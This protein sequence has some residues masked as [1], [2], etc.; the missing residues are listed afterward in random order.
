MATH[1]MLAVLS[2]WEISG[3]RPVFV[4][5]RRSGVAEKRE[6]GVGGD[7]QGLPPEGLMVPPR[8]SDTNGVAT[9][10]SSRLDL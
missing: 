4:S 9:R 3:V 7:W 5:E 2:W 6:M 10:A 8:T 1:F